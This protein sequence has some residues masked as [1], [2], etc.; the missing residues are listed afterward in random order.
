[1]SGMCGKRT[2]S[3][4]DIRRFAM[5]SGLTPMLVRAWLEAR[6]VARGLPAPVDDYDGFR[7]DTRNS[8]ETARWVFPEMKPGLIQ[9]GQTV[10]QPGH[11]IKLC[12]GLDELRAVLPARWQPHLPG[13]FIARTRRV[14]QSN[15]PEG[16]TA[17][18]VT[19]GARASARIFA[20][21]GT[22][23]AS[24][25][26]AETDRAFIYD[27][28]ETNPQHRRAGL[29]RALMS[30]LRNAKTRPSTP[31]LLVATEAGRKLYEAIGWQMISVY[32]TASIPDADPQ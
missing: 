10:S 29:G 20:R 24:G 3:N 28:I 21:D 23:A 7:V 25:Y 32:S 11:L 5:P 4:G 19:D 26:A 14:A 8:A 16:Y 18:V 9:L 15:V 31:E 12:G 22:V 30:V 2:F 6:S 27:R 1:M 13:Y 17:E